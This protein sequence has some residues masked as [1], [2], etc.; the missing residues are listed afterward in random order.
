LKIKNHA[1]A[2]DRAKNSDTGAVDR[3]FCRAALFSQE[4]IVGPG[5]E[6]ARV[7]ERKG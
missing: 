3:I 6:A 1:T 7:K 4:K 2:N 5:T